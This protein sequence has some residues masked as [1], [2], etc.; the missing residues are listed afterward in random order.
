M[1]FSYA[2]VNKPQAIFVGGDLLSVA[3]TIA[4]MRDNLD[5][6]Q[7]VPEIA[8]KRQALEAADKVTAPSPSKALIPTL[9]AQ[10]LRAL[11]LSCPSHIFLL[12]LPSFVLRAQRLNSMAEPRLNTAFE[13]RNVEGAQSALKVFRKSGREDAFHSLY[14]SFRGTQVIPQAL[15]QTDSFCPFPRPLPLTACQT[16]W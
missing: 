13:T 16:V 2:A 1:S 7:D 10:T 8:V 6:L 15:S 9:L 11:S 12:L 14:V 3:D 4:K 5:A